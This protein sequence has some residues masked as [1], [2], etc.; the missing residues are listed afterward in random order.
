MSTDPRD[1][2]YALLSLL[3]EGDIARETISISYGQ[4]LF[5]LYYQVAKCLFIGYENEHE[6]RKYE[7]LAIVQEC[8][9]IGH[10]EDNAKTFLRTMHEPAG[11]YT[12]GLEVVGAFKLVECET[13]QVHNHNALID[14]P[15]LNIGILTPTLS[16]SEAEKHI[17]TFSKPFHL[18]LEKIWYTQTKDIK[19]VH[20]GTYEYHDSKMENVQ[21]HTNVRSGDILLQLSMAVDGLA[22]AVFRRAN[23]TQKYHLHSWA[24]PM[25][26]GIWSQHPNTRQLIYHDSRKLRTTTHLE[27]LR[28]SLH[29]HDALFVMLH[30]KSPQSFLQPEIMHATEVT[31]PVILLSQLEGDMAAFFRLSNE[32]KDEEEALKGK[33]S[34]KWKGL[35]KYLKNI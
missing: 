21:V 9:N 34:K 22:Y 4:P 13:W 19:I 29:L 30:K 15:G 25:N 26:S 5:Q 3:P 33:S 10:N 6:H 2:I 16:R 17:L 11:N 7:A 14:H 24:I 32:M 35:R 12:F 1:K 27:A 28:V 23:E 8:Y 20:M 31:I 18:A